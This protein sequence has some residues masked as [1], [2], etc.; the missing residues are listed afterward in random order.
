MNY[1][2]DDLSFVGLWHEICREMNAEQKAW[3]A[4]LRSQGIK[5]SH[6][7]D[8]WVDRKNNTLQFVYPQF[9]DGAKAGDLVALGWPTGSLPSG[10]HRI[11]RLKERKQTTFSEYWSFESR[12]VL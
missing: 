1:V 12:E 8:G 9:N 11:V 4:Q 10:N 5:A 2:S 6:P 7:D 3:I